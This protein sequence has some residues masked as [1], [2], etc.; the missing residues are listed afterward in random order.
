ML[1]RA[2]AAQALQII[3]IDVPVID[4]VTTL[5]Q[6]VTDHILARPFRATRRGDCDEIARRR[7][8]GVEMASTASRILRLISVTLMASMPL[9]FPERFRAKSIQVRVTKTRQ[10]KN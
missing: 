9:S 3:D 7:Q 1:D 10:N 5:S 8:L 2:E 6:E 4:L